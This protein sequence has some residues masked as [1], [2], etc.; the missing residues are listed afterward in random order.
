[1]A[2]FF[3]AI[4]IF[5]DRPFQIG[6]WVKIDDIE[7]TVEDVGFRT[8][9]IRT[10]YNSL[11]TI[12]NAKLTG[13]PVD[14]LGARDY[15]RIKTTLG[16]TYST[17]P[18]QMQAFV[19]GIR[20]IIVAHP[21]TRKDYYEI[22]F[23]G[24]GAY[25]LDVLLYCFVITPTWSDELKAKHEIFLSILK[26]AKD[27][28]VEFA[29]PTRSLFVNSFPGHDPKTINQPTRDQL[30]ETVLSYGPAGELSHPRGFP[31]TH[32]YLAKTEETEQELKKIE[33]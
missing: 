11:V 26:L 2:N 31:L 22:H 32:G 8:T 7:G 28:G 25:S 33:T 27:V 9:R 10:F 1:V 23:N 14:N 29:F 5:I 17:T 30:A 21:E 18:N 20:A 19:E 15:R 13:T 3:G 16:L 24:F 6:D 4:T 12:P